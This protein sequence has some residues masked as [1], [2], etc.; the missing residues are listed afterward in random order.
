MLSFRHAPLHFPPNFVFL[1]SFLLT[2]VVLPSFGLNAAFAANQDDDELKKSSPSEIYQVSTQSLSELSIAIKH[3]AVAEVQ[4]L[5]SSQLASEI[6]AIVKSV[7]VDVGD[8]VKK[9]AELLRLDCRPYDIELLKARASADVAA[10]KLIL[11]N[12][13]L[14]SAKK[15][16]KESFLPEDTLLQRQAEYQMAIGE[17][18]AR[19]AQV[20]GA[21][22][23]VSRCRI[24]APFDAVV[25]ERIAQEGEY[26]GRG[27]AVLKLLDTASV[28]VI[29][30]VAPKDIE[31]LN[32]AKNL[33]FHY[34]NTQLPL[35]LIKLSSFVSKKS[36]T[37]TARL[38]F[39]AAIADIGIQGQ[40]QWGDVDYY[41]PS[42]L[43]VSREGH[44]G[45]FMLKGNK[46]SF[47]SLPD[48]LEGR[49]AKVNLAS[50]VP[51]ITQGRFQL[52]DGDSVTVN[53]E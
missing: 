11:A 13:Q 5:N 38:N 2:F 49:P 30:N 50:D 37:Y 24:L 27:K 31:S 29:A 7:G 15:L 3:V 22:L 19:I 44:L 39:S 26:I 8:S 1:R 17:E 45:V 48:A 25:V 42:K 12:T 43:V 41:L 9:G 33:N 51:I 32:L 14:K 4:S 36:G 47:V 46:A 23:D 20:Q 52:N 10:A 35:E 18:R 53:F 28:Q 6:S 34:R 21:V 40:L 16:A